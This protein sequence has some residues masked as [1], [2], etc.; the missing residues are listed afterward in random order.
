MNYLACLTFDLSSFLN[1]RNV[2]PLFPGFPGFGVYL[3]THSVS[4]IFANS[5]HFLI[6]LGFVTSSFF[7]F[8]IINLFSVFLFLS[9]SLYFFSTICIISRLYYF[10]LTMFF[11]YISSLSLFSTYN[12]LWY[13]SFYSINSTFCYY[14]LLLSYS[15]HYLPNFPSSSNMKTTSSSL[16]SIS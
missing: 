8:R 11:L 15:A 12:V 16:F 10:P 3:F 13:E 6:C 7:F 2:F 14:F 4:I 1:P 5:L 9:F